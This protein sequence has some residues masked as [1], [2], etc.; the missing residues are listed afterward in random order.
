MSGYEKLILL[1]QFLHFP[2]WISQLNKGIFSRQEILDLHFGQKLL[3][4]AIEMLR[5]NL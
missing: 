5:G 2:F 4:L 3:G 1:S